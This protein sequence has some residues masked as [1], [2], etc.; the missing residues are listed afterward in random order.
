MTEAPKAPGILA[1]PNVSEG[2][3][4]E[5]IERVE[6]AFAEGSAVLDRH[7]DATHNRSVFSLLPNDG[8]AAE[9]LAR[10]AREA[11]AAIDL[12]NHEGEHPHIGALDVAPVIYL[13]PES[14]EEA[15]AKALNSR[16]RDRRTRCP[17]LSLRRACVCAGAP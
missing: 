12:S 4:A 17:G 16:G 13:S 8:R 6:S 1:V 2:R 14:R 5:L 7:S 11:I 3:D 10:G 15:R 9:T